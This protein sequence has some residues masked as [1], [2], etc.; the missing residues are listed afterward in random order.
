MTRINNGLECCVVDS[1][2]ND[3]D[4]HVYEKRIIC[5]FDREKHWSDHDYRY[6]N[7]IDDEDDSSYAPEIL[8]TILK[9]HIR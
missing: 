5:H 2:D 4:V 7:Q 9:N 6:S 8:Q 3:D 1:V